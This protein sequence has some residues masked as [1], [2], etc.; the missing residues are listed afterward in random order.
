MAL[1]DLLRL[2]A[3]FQHD[4][5]KGGVQPISETG[6]IVAIEQFKSQVMNLEHELHEALDEMG[7]KD[8]ASSNHWNEDAVKSELIDAL[9]F[10]MNLAII[11]ELSPIEIDLIYKS[12]LDKTYARITDGYDGVTTKCPA[13][14]RAYD[15][16]FVGCHVYD[17]QYSIGWCE[18]KQIHTN[19]SGEAM[20]WGVAGWSV[21]ST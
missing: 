14:K 10:W 6:T 2:Q 15:D 4:L 3:Q 11:A 21:S 20:T 16:K 9:R 7:W 1:A 5:P 8:W 13:C 17:N 18:I 12:S 19:R